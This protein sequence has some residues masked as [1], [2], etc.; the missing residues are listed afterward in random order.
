[1]SSYR[2]LLCHLHARWRVSPHS[3][4]CASP[5]HSPPDAHLG[6]QQRTPPAAAAP[7]PICGRLKRKRSVGQRQARESVAS[8][9][10]GE[11]LAH[12]Q[13]KMTGSTAGLQLRGVRGGEKG[14]V[15]DKRQMRLSLWGDIAKQKY[16][17]LSVEK[18]HR[19]RHNIYISDDL[20]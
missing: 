17:R 18:T 9:Q 16:Q 12:M 2:L 3:G 8:A 15:G 6:S 20:N 19:R 5:H 13:S 14:S 10:H 11:I 7:G 4:L 1:M